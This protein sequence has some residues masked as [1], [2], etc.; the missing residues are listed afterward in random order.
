MSR[1]GFNPL[2]IGSYFP[3]QSTRVD[4]IILHEF[5]SPIHRVLF[6]YKTLTG[7]GAPTF[8]VSIPY[9][10]GLIFL[11]RMIQVKTSY[12][13]RF[14]PLFIGSYF[15]TL[16]S[17]LKSLNRLIVSIPYSSGLIFLRQNPNTWFSPLPSFNPLF[18]GSYFPT[19]WLRIC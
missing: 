18:I 12:C 3:T 6:S 2:F 13:C 11:R 1:P 8:L 5:Q 15:P 9:S 17:E 7:W 4:W 16:N 19:K 10:S 14:N